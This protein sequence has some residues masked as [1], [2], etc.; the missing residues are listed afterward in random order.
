MGDFIFHRTSA[1]DPLLTTELIINSDGP[2]E[3]LLVHLSA[4]APRRLKVAVECELDRA[5]ARELR[6]M[7]NHWLGE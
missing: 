4:A 7:L 5:A 1:D 6:D 3:D 2:E